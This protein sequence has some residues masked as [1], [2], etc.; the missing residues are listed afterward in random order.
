MIKT[1][2]KLGIVEMYF[3]IIKAIYDKLKANLMLNGQMLE[4]FL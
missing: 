3:N 2:K 4:V 1:L